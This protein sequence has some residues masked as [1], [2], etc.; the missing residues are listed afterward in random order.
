MSR[1]GRIVVCGVGLKG[2]ILIE[3]ILKKG[4]PIDQ[5]VTYRQSDDR[6]GSFE[7]IIEVAARHS[8]NMLETCNPVAQAEDLIFLIGWQ[9]FLPVVTPSTIV[10]HDSLLPRYRGFAPTVTAL[11]NGDREIGVTALAPTQT[12]DA[13]PIIAQRSLP[14]SYPIKIQ[15]ALEQ[16]AVLMID[17]AVEIVERW[18]RR[19]LSSTPQREDG[20]TFS[21]WRDEADYEIDW[22]KSAHAIERFV[23]AVGYP[24]AGATTIVGEERIRVLDVTSL[25]DMRFEIRDVGKIWNLENGRPTIVC[26]DGMLK[27]NNCCH[28]DGSEFLFRRLRMRLGRSL[29]RNLSR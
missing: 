3:G 5:I 29:I 9:Y 27:I 16:Q 22:S 13:G 7:R 28:E 12:I 15:T 4:I 24:Y 8:I 1:T 6:S 18:Q 20:A 11:I 21:I 10:F 2:A 25:P 19:E 14:I 23:N 26:G 17:I